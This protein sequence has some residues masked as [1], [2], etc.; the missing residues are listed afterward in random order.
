MIRTF[1]IREVRS[2]ILIVVVHCDDDDG[3][4]LWCVSGLLL[5]V[6]QTAGSRGD[7]GIAAGYRPTNLLYYYFFLCTGQLEAL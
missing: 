3:I 6:C 7:F 4:I 5:R 2:F 1:E